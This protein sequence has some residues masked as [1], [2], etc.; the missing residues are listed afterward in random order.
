MKAFHSQSKRNAC[1]CFSVFPFRFSNRPYCLFTRRSL[2]PPAPSPRNGRNGARGRMSGF[3]GTHMAADALISPLL[4]LLPSPPRGRRAGDEGVTRD[5]RAVC[6]ISGRCSAMLYLQSS[7]RYSLV[8]QKGYVASD[9]KKTARSVRIGHPT[10]LL[11]SCGLRLRFCWPSRNFAR[12]E[13]DLFL[14]ESRFTLSSQ[15]HTIP[16]GCNS[17]PRFH[18][19]SRSKVSLVLDGAKA[20]RKPL[21]V[22]RSARWCIAFRRFFLGKTG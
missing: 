1:P 7:R 2:T 12:L 9:Q 10:D 19:E 18:P 21:F 20:R 16:C 13:N 22:L 3:R 15:H 5:E 8:T 14:R 17:L 11:T 6:G 4:F